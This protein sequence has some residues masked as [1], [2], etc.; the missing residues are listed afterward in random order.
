MRGYEY[1]SVGPLD[2][3]TDPLGGRSVLELG[4]ELRFRV[5]DDYGIVPFVDAGTVGDNSV[6]D[7]GNELLWAA[8]LGL[9]Y[10]TSI[11]PARLDFAFPI[12]GRSGIDDSFQFYISLGQAF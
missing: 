7:F 5:F 4:A 1:Q 8:G 9:R 12:N 10:Y 3:A 2:G 11:G 6:P